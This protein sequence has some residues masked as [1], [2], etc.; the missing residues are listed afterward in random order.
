MRFVVVRGRLVL[1]GAL[2]P[3][4]EKMI[5]MRQFASDS[6]FG[7]FTVFV[8]ANSRMMNKW[9]TAE[10]DF[11]PASLGAVGVCVGKENLEQCAI[12]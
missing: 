3:P 8:R 2:E 11:A 7:I 6:I 12:G 4:T 10:G 9:K 1:P 5:K